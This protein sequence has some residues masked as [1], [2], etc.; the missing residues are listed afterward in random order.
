MFEFPIEQYATDIHLN[1]ST[2]ASSRF[3]MSCESS[4]ERNSP[5]AELNT[6]LVFSIQLLGE[7]RKTG[8]SDTVKRGLKR[9]QTSIN[10]ANVLRSPDFVRFVLPS[11]PNRKDMSWPGMQLPDCVSCVYFRRMNHLCVEANP[12]A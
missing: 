2:S 8:I 4:A 1:V 6:D 3:D 7:F 9:C 10:I 5:S 12:G 11:P